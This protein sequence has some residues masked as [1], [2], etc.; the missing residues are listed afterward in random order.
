MLKLLPY[1]DLVDGTLASFYTREKERRLKVFFDELDKGTI[2]LTEE[3]IQ[4]DDFL[5][6]YFITVKAAVET[7]R[8]EKI[9]YFARLL[10]NGNSALINDKTDNYEDFLKV[11]DELTNQEI[12][13][14]LFVRK[15]T[16][17]FD[18]G[19]GLSN[20]AVY[21]PMKAALATALDVSEDEVRS[22]FVRLERT[23][24]VH[25]YQG[26]VFNNDVHNYLILSDTYKKLE[27]LVQI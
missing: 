13:I 24:L 14:L 9:Q 27:L 19:P 6:K 4:K 17:E 5:H 10:M 11:L 16:S 7:K 1:G 21:R 23:G 15:F 20:M 18:K 12:F 26:S 22:Y 2:S 3:D 25:H 8:D